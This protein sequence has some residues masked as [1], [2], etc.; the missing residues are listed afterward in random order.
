MNV[1]VV[2]GGLVG[3]HIA[4]TLA[5]EH[6]DVTL[7]EQDASRLRQIDGSMDCLTEIGRAH[8]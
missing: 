7:I 1:I 3:T 6:H 5:T 2:G 4:R 8:V